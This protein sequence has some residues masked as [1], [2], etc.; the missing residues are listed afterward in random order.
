MSSLYLPAGRGTRGSGVAK[1]I[2]NKVGRE[3]IVRKAKLALQNTSNKYPKLIQ[4]QEGFVKKGFFK[5]E[6]FYK[7]IRI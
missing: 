2:N 6:Y 3:R 7:T 1:L 4:P 5:N